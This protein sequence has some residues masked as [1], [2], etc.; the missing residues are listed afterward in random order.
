MKLYLFGGAE[1]ELGQV[2][3]LIGSINQAISEIK[4]KQLLHV[5][6]ARLHVPKGEEDFWGEGWVRSKLIN[7]GPEREQLITVIYLHG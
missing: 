1:V 6:Y 5:P 7:G 4:P 3:A 2:E